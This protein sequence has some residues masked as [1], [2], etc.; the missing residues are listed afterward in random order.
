MAKSKKKRSESAP[1]VAAPAGGKYTRTRSVTLPTLKLVEEQ[2]AYVKIISPMVV[3]NVTQKPKAGEAPKEPATVC[4]VANVE[5]GEL[6]QMIC[7]AA[8]KGVLNESY[9][10]DGYVGKSFE[11]TKHAKAPGKRY[12]TYSVFEIDA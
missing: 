6:A 3:S 4:Q 5:T 7:G 2:T 9:P 8:L 1:V 11:V 12:N 10:E